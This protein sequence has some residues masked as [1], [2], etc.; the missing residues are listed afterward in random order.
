M[1]VAPVLELLDERQKLCA[2]EAVVVQMTGGSVRSGH[3]HRALAPQT[4]E[5]LPDH[6]RVCD[7]RHLK[8]VSIESLNGRD[9]DTVVNQP[10]I[11]EQ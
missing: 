1:H 6:H 10:S 11:L 5:E 7:I 3:H 9:L 8:Y 2:L 4:G